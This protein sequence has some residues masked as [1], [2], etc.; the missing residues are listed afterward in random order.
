MKKFT[1]IILNLF[2]FISYTSL[3]AQNNFIIVKK[4][5]FDEKI[6]SSKNLIKNYDF[7]Q[8][9]DSDGNSTLS[10]NQWS[11]TSNAG[12]TGG[13][14]NI[15]INNKIAHI[16]ISDGGKEVYSVQLIQTPILL[17]QS[18]VYSIEF[19]AKADKST[20]IFIKMG[21][22]ENRN[23]AD[24]TNG[25]GHGIPIELTT[26]FKRYI[27][28][29]T[30]EKPSDNQARLEFQLG[31]EGNRNIYLSDITLNIIGRKNM[32]IKNIPQKLVEIPA[33]KIHIN[34]I[35]YLPYDKK[36]VI[37][38]SKEII[39]KFNLVNSDNAEIVYSNKLK[40]KGFDNATG[41]YIFYGDFS[42]YTNSG[43]YYINIPNF[44]NSF[45]FKIDE[46]IYLDLKFALEKMLYFQRASITLDEKYANKWA[47]KKS[48]TEKAKLLNK[49]IYL[50]VSGGWFDAGDYGRYVVPASTTIG[51][52][53]LAYKFFPEKF[54]DNTNIPESNNGIPD[55]L[56]ECKYALEWLLKMQSENG[57][58]YH[59]VTTSNFVSMI[60]PDKNNKELILSPISATA[61]ANF[62]AVTAMASRIYN[63][64]KKFSNKLL[65]ASLKSWK[66]LENNPNVPGFKNPS[67]ISTGEYGD[68]NDL[69]E[70]FW[71]AVEL[72]S[73]TKQEKYHIYIKN[74]I[75]DIHNLSSF[76]WEDVGGFASTTYLMLDPKYQSNTIKNII[77]DKFI[78]KTNT[79]INISKNE[80]YKITLNKN[81]Y[82]WGS[83]M[84][85][86]T[87]AMLLIIT[88]TLIK[89]NSKYIET[90]KFN[91]DYLLGLNS[92]DK[93][94]ITGFGSRPVIN[95]HHRPSIADEIPEP[96][97]GMVSGG[98]NSRFQDDT[99]K[100]NL[101]KDT[102][103]AKCYVDLEGSY[104]TNEITTYW[105]SPAIFVVNYFIK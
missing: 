4:E 37:I 52:L 83:N 88:N 40:E 87:D 15:E 43:N 76:G 48:Y 81:E 96:I 67:S 56:D 23:W 18:Y 21:S 30:M 28:Q 3:F 86:M 7:E 104:S 9:I 11:L 16:N 98:P 41:D 27:I 13:K 74:I 72:Y 47:R 70:R 63:F 2:I 31:K 90:A 80:G 6:I 60:M 62:V 45:S 78:N 99:I 50:D 32:K 59:K 42:D 89:N 105:N 75:Q 36:L 1:L 8:N 29:F 69:D 64:D 103:F 35:G 51:H 14:A 102:P 53:L 54:T 57:G 19:N 65:Q 66:W 24:Y 82:A 79:L 73:T 26:N 55:I 49:N 95:P 33:K 25:N 39:N 38:N 91:L 68:N 22:R 71:A 44:D 84:K 10:E 77:S 12:N 94:F 97:P 46:N 17:K 92:L 5:T 100:N 20:S 85:V 58:V 101:S 93:S 34:Q 61:T